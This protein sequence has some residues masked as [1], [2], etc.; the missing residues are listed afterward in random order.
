M[1]LGRVGV[2]GRFRP[3]HNGGAV[4]LEELCRQADEVVIGIGS[5][6][7]YNVR[8][9]FTPEETKGFID[10]YLSP[11]F[12]NYTTRF[13]DDYG[14]IPDYQDG[15]EWRR[16]IKEMFG[17][18]DHFVTGNPYVA[19]LLRDDYDIVH[20][21]TI[22]PKARHLFLRATQVR[23]EMARGG[24]WMR[25]VPPAVADYLEKNGLVDR[26]T[27]EFGLATL[28]EL[29]GDRHIRGETEDEERGHAREG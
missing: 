6:N 21:A 4:M 20:P 5:A 29:A 1:S 18:L 12:K 14:H 24:D 25:L 2:V 26:F 17:A 27:R 13:I 15:Q 22:I 3:L 23:I 16:H 7:K 19:G 8:N 11:R 28:A 10:A 9:P